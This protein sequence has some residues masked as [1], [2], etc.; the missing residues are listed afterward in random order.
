[1]QLQAPTLPASVAP[2]DDLPRM[3]AEAAQ[4]QAGGLQA[5]DVVVVAQKVVSKIANCFV[6]VDNVEPGAK[7]LELA[8]IIKRDPRL[9]EVVLSESIEVVLKSTI[10]AS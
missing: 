7:A 3:I 2:S 4:E 8:A 10:A 5:G 9:I 6:N 1:M